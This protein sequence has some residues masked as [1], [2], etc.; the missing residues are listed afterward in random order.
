MRCESNTNTLI[1][2]HFLIWGKKYFGKFFFKKEPCSS[3][4]SLLRL[5]L[6]SI[7]FKSRNR[8]RITPKRVAIRP[9]SLQPQR[10]FRCRGRRG[11][12]RA[13]TALDADHAVVG[14]VHVE[15]H[16]DGRQGGRE[17][18]VGQPCDAPRRFCLGPRG[19]DPPTSHLLGGLRGAHFLGSRTT[20]YQ[21]GRGG[22]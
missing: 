6:C 21:P 22:V 12:R 15:Q 13:G 3:L 20:P 10:G 11:R 9:A 5:R 19:S 14:A 17:Q 16:A 4:Y 1:F 2:G 8:R 18:P 7:L